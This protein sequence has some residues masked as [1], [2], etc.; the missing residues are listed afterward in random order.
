MHMIFA[1]VIK[2]H[3]TYILTLACSQVLKGKLNISVGKMKAFPK[4]SY[5]NNPFP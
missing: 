5:I 3:L 1:I 2:I 4:F